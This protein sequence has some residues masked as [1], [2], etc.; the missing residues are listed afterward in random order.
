MRWTLI[1]HTKAQK[2]ELRGW[3]IGIGSSRKDKK[4][5]KLAISPLA[6]GLEGTLAQRVNVFVN[7]KVAGVRGRTRIMLEV[8]VYP[9]TAL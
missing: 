2:G 8:H 5:E 4:P 9:V 3:G 7:H 1:W 6:Q